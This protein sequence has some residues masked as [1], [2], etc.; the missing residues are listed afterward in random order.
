MT[1]PIKKVSR[2]SRVEPYQT[3]D[4]SEI[5]ELMHPDVQG[6][7]RQSLAQ[8]SVPA[9]AKTLLH[10]HAITE[11]LYFIQSGRG[12]MTLADETF[13]VEAG[14]TICIPPGIAHCI[15]NSADTELL[16]L[17]CCSPAY[18]HEDTEIL[19]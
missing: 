9:G 16:L 8:A 5:R 6:N 15:E 3:K 2:L 17:C 14:D 12:E 1:N 7:Q 10:R 13:P 4:R 18:S 11:E 19:V